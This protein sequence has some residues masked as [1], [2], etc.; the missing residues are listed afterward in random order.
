MANANLLAAINGMA[1]IAVGDS[2]GAPLDLNTYNI[3]QDIAVM[4]GKIPATAPNGQSYDNAATSTTAYVNP[5]LSVY[6]AQAKDIVNAAAAR[7]PGANA[8]TPS[9]LG[10]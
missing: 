4:A 2:G 1:A 8:L 9:L 10:A 7:Q 5:T 6:N 3:L